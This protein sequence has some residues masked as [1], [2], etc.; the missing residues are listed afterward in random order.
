ML[1]KAGFLSDEV[2]ALRFGQG[3]EG[4]ALLSRGEEGFNDNPGSVLY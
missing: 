2:I 1:R 4:G 3:G